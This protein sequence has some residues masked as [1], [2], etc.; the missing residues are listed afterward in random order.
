V[1]TNAWEVA[2]LDFHS[3]RIQRLAEEHS[4]PIG[5][6]YDVLGENDVAIYKRQ[7]TLKLLLDFEE[8]EFSDVDISLARRA[9][10]WLAKLAPSH[11]FLT[12]RT[13]TFRYRH[14]RSGWSYTLPRWWYPFDTTPHVSE[15]DSDF[16]LFL[17][18]IGA[19]KPGQERLL[20]RWQDVEPMKFG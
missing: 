6:F 20:E 9:P 14:A 18:R 16:G 8:R 1:Y 5:G 15:E 2:E 10:T 13:I 4:Y 3:K 7:G 17:C 19:D 12:Q 11:S